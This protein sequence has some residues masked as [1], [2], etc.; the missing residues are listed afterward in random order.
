VAD[1]TPLPVA[2]LPRSARRNRARGA[3]T[4]HTGDCITHSP[5]RHM[6]RRARSPPRPWNM[7]R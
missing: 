7:R 6:P 3:F 5:R 2:S 1:T 4:R